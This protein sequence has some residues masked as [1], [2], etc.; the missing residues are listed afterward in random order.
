[1]SEQPT[2]VNDIAVL[3]NVGLALEA[4]EATFARDSSLPGIMCMHGRSG[5]GKSS[6]AAYLAVKFDA[7]FIQ[8]YDAW[9]RRAYYEAI[10]KDMGIHDIKGPNWKL[11]EVICQELSDTQRMLIIDEADYLVDK[12]MAQMV[13]DFFEGSGSPILMIGE[14][15]LR[16][17]LLT[18]HAKIERRVFKWIGAQP[19]TLKDCK[20]LAQMYVP[21]VT[22]EEEFLE[23]INKSVDGCTGRVAINLTEVRAAAKRAKVTEVTREWWG[24]RELPFDQSETRRGR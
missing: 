12:G 15:N 11:L 4:V 9:P 23:H 20:S 21:G 13:M 1:M 18:K 2:T 19:A 14:E 17:K 7:C 24:D 10:L 8:G 6:A 3:S 16:R 22:V 5:L